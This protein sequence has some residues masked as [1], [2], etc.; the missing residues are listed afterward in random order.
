VARFRQ[1]FYISPLVLRRGH[2][3]PVVDL[4]DAPWS[5]IADLGERRLVQ[6][7]AK[8]ETIARLDRDGRL[9]PVTG[10]AFSLLQELTHRD[11]GAERLREALLA[12]SDLA[13]AVR[14]AL[15]A[16]VAPRGE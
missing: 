15:D 1:R 11:G 6:V 9:E 13:A 2:R 3:R 5:W 7:Y 14:R 10:E 16:P 12:T 4:F 8:A